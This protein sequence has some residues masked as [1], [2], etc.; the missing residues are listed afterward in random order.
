MH[1]AKSTSGL[2]ERNIRALVL[3]RQ[4]EEASLG[5]QERIAARVSSF[6]GSMTFV[7]LHV[8][9][10]GGWIATNVGLLPILPRFDPTFVALAMTA[11]VEAIFLSTFILITQNRMQARAERRADLDLQ[12]SL[13]AEHEITRLVQMVGEI[14]RKLGAQTAQDP[15]LAELERDVAPEAV[16]DAIASEEAAR[17]SPERD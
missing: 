8:V 9:L 15:H 11:S 6:A 2:V 10:F 14:G 12:V 13:L 5:W 17:E 7:W 16:L 3:R 1:N 4:Q